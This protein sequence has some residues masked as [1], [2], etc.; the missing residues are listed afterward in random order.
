VL[1]AENCFV[2][3]YDKESDLFNKVFLVDKHDPNS[4]PQRLRKSCSAYVFRTGQPLLMSKEQLKD[5]IKRGDVD[6]VGTL[7]SSWLG[8]PLKT[9]TETTGVLVVQNYER[10]GVYS[11]RDVDFLSSVGD[12]I[13]LAIERKR[14]EEALTK[15][16]AKFKELF[17][18]APVGYHEL[19][20]EGRIIRVNLTEQRLLGY[21]AEEMLG[22]FGWDFI[23]EKV[24][25]E[26]IAEG[27]RSAG[28]ADVAWNLLWRLAQRCFWADPGRAARE[29]VVDAAEHA[30]PLDA[31]P[32]ALAVVAYTAPLSTHAASRHRCWLV[33]GAAN[34]LPMRKYARPTRSAARIQA[35][36]RV[37]SMCA[38]T[39]R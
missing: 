16:E 23:V 15:S 11:R 8:V 19:D 17:D 36:R 1:Y 31:D 24:S 33:A 38:L 4:S 37:A 18:H 3:L 29:V 30:G 39:R 25:Q 13:A 28:D 21:S 35:R 34:T 10:E 26:A 14:T 22:R 27:A 9:P 2:A 7:S 12:Q 5:L 32:R 20:K 6:L